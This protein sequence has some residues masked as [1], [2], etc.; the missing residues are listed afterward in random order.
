[1]NQIKQDKSDVPIT[2]NLFKM[3]PIIAEL[4]TRPG[5]QI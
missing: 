4:K 5:E 2:I 1:M 3:A